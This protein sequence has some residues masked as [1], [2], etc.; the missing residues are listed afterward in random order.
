MLS[1]SGSR[2]GLSTPAKVDAARHLLPS[3]ATT[4]EIAGANHAD[5]GAYG[6]QPGDRTAAISRAEA[7]RQIGDAVE[8]WVRGLH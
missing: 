5:F 1:V 3:T 7:R 6:D 8:E 2:D 4:T